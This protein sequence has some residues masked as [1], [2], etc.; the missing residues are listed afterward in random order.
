VTGPTTP[1]PTSFSRVLGGTAT[2]HVERSLRAAVADDQVKSILMRYESPG[3][4]L[5][6]RSW[7]IACGG[8]AQQKPLSATSTTWALGRDALL[9][10]GPPRDR[11]PHRDVGSI[12]VMS[13]P[14]I[15]SSGAAAAKGPAR[16]PDRVRQVEDARHGGRARH[17]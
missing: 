17:R 12:G 1:Q 16:L 10:A 15:D 6:R 3:G 5:A 8:P 4:T 7:S 11:Q 14:L 9:R 13:Q 2:S